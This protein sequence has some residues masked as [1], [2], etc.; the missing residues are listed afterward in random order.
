MTV[1]IDVQNQVIDLTVEDKVVDV[2]VIP[3][4]AEINPVSQVVEI[5]VENTPFIIETENQV[6]DVVSVGIQGDQGPRG[7][8]GPSGSGGFNLTAGETINANMPIKV[9]ADGFAY[10]ASNLSPD[11]FYNIVG[12]SQTSAL[13]GEELLVTRGE[14]HNNSWSWGAGAIYVGDK[15][16]TQT[17][18]AA[19]FIQVIAT[20]I[21][22]VDIISTLFAPVEL[23]SS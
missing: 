13:I 20:A 6:V 22:S 18:P 10:I 23:A 21:S 4:V 3:V 7:V 16:L 19:G 15:T 1:E 17:P 9:N 11:D 2:T 8:P 5:T 14:S 12:I